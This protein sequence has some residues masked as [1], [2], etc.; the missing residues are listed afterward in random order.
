MIRSTEAQIEIPN[1][2][3]CAIPMRLQRVIPSATEDVESRIFVCDRCRTE[4][5]R[6]V[7]LGN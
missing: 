6:I 7:R 3:D 4:I 1:C 2:P 5:I